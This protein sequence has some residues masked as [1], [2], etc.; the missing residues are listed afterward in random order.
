MAEEV[1][2]FRSHFSDFGGKAYLDCAAQGPFPKE[3]AEEVR[4]ALRLKE[5]PEEI[6]E[7]LFEEVPDRVRAAV[8]RLI[9]C[10]PANVA[11]GT[12]AS[13]GINLAARGLPLRRGDEILLVE[14]EF[15]ANVCPW[16][17]LRADGMSVRMVQPATDRGID[18]AT[19]AAAMGPKTRVVAI[20]LVAFATGYRIDMQALGEA[21]R[22]HGS[23]LVV[24]GAQGIGALD[25]RVADH[26]ID[27]LAVSGY[28]WLLGPYGSGFVYVSPRILERLRVADINWQGVEGADRMNRSS[29]YTALKFKD[30]ARR[31]DSH[32]TASFLNLSALAASIEFVN[33][34]KVP[35]VEAHVRRLLDQAVL[36]VER[37]RLR[38]VS[39]LTP[40]RRSGIL[41]LAGPTLD[42]TRTIYRRLR[43]R[44]IVVSLRKN[45]VRVSPHIYNTPDDIGRFLEAAAG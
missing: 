37:T 4:R 18:A 14:G 27:V 35:T 15:P 23:F 26:A 33:R 34:V 43:A 24:D 10:N 12:G 38:V 29:D 17:G 5:H 44:G 32:E 25:F 28:K 16:L 22:E 39:D 41:A 20:S 11:V 45:L 13:H 3:T 7:G 30:G 21:C 8:A 1:T 36:G 9:G 6:T 42:D 31:F 40:A 2:L 19:L